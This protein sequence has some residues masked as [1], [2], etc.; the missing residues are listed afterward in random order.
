VRTPSNLAGMGLRIGIVGLPNVGKSTLFNALTG[1]EI[2]AESY[3]FTTLEPNV[4]VAMVSDPR[5]GDIAGIIGSPTIHPS[6]IEFVDIAGLV[7]GASHGEGLGNQFLHHIRET[8]AIA[9]VVRAFDDPNVAH[10]HGIVDPVA[11]LAI[12]DT[13]LIIAD[14]DTVGRAIDKAGRQAR[15]GDKE[16]AAHLDLLGKIRD[17]LA[18]GEPLRTFELSGAAAPIVRELFL[19]TAKPVMYVVNVGEEDPAGALVDAVREYAAGEDADVVVMAAELEEELAQL[20]DADRAAMLTEYGLAESG[21][22]R[23]IAAAHRLL[24]LRTFFTANENEARSWTVRSG[25]K[26]PQAAGQIHTD[27]ERGFIKAEVVSYDDLVAAGSEHAAKE[28]GRW[29]IEGRDYVVEEGDV[30]LFRFN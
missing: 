1:G 23:V 27:F 26:A 25:T 19:L 3:P 14:L 2:A 9:H 20:D 18:A 30:M 21:L 22:D 11:D 4:G 28:A 5:L 24:D 15:A 10:V 16:A 17:H 13:E 29:R 6:V 8:D 7:E 12:V